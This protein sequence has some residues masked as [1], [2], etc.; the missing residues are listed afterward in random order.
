MDAAK[1]G[2]AIEAMDSL[3]KRMDAYEQRY[4]VE[5]SSF[6]LLGYVQAWSEEEAR[7][8]A[9]IKFRKAD[10]HVRLAQ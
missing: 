3:S 7:R 9:T 4:R 2:A 1:L 6:I 10:L 8:A 5:N